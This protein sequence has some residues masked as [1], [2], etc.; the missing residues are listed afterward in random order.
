ML[1]IFINVLGEGTFDFNFGAIAEPNKFYLGE[2]GQVFDVD[3]VNST[4]PFASNFGPPDPNTAEIFFEENETMI[5]AYWDDRS[6][7]DGDPF[8]LR[9]VA[10]KG[11]LFGWLSLTFD[12]DTLIL[13]ESVT[14]QGQGVIVG[15]AIPVIPEPAIFAF[16]VSVVSLGFVVLK[17]R[18]RPSQEKSA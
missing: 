13:N 18:L 8:E 14:V 17:Q 5:F 16:V 3:F 6:L 9:E 15:T 11:D 7:F 4:P 12:G 2:V 10:D 1:A